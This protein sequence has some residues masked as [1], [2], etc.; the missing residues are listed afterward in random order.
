MAERR[1]FSKSVLDS[2][3]FL[4]LSFA[5]QCL[6]FHL[7]LRADA[8]GFVN[9][10]RKIKKMLGCSETD[11]EELIKHNFIYLFDSGIIVIMYWKVHNWI[12][13]DRYKTTFHQNEKNY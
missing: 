7:A 8:D 5:T 2:D 10:V 4:N 3:D 11:I 9:S 12:Q 1:M 13:K 6:Y